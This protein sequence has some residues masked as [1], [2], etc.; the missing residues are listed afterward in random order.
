MFKNREV[1]KRKQIAVTIAT[2]IL[3]IKNVDYLIDKDNNVYTYNIDHPRM[4]GTFDY[5]NQIIVSKN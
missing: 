2:K 3:N 1:E 4:L 5:D